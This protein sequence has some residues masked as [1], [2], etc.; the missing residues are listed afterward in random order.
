MKIPNFVKILSLT[1]ILSSC[2]SQS[3]LQTAVDN[4]KRLEILIEKE[5]KENDLL[6]ANRSVFE[7]QIQAL[8]TQVQKI[9]AEKTTISE[10]YNTSLIK[11]KD[12]KNKL[13]T[14]IK[15][16]EGT[17]NQQAENNRL[18]VD[19]L[20]EK[21]NDLAEDKQEL[22]NEKYQARKKVVKRKRRRR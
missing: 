5:R 9:Q 8:N 13:E 14:K 15:A 7:A 3:Q 18:T 17:I 6:N 12:E 10:A 22:I 4:S 11:S 16:L 20:G 21:L 1:V 2:V 19:A